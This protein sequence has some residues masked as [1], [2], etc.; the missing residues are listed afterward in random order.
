[1][2]EPHLA[3]ENTAPQAI[4]LGTKP[5]K[6][7]FIHPCAQHRKVLNSVITLLRTQAHRHTQQDF[8]EAAAMRCTDEGSIGGGIQSVMGAPPLSPSVSLMSTAHCIRPHPLDPPHQ[9]LL[10]D[11]LLLSCGSV[12]LL[13]RLHGPSPFHSVT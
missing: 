11:A 6:I 3:P 13:L 8:D 12:L 2:H 10:I 5:D 7:E 9:H 4:L 1:M